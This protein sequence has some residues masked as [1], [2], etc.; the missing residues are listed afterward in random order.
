MIGTFGGARPDFATEAMGINEGDTYLTLRPMSTW[1]RLHTREALIA[2]LDRV[3]STVPDTAYDFTQPMAMRIDETVSGVKAD[4][5]IK[6]FGDVFNT[7]DRLGQQIWFNCSIRKPSRT[8]SEDSAS[9]HLLHD[10]YDPQIPEICGFGT[11]FQISGERAAAINGPHL[12]QLSHYCYMFKNSS[13]VLASPDVRLI[14]IVSQH[15]Q[16]VRRL[17]RC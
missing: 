10:C 7:L 8:D 11:H 2:A 5:I 12:S 6:V 17:R 9:R 14:T 3:L 4:L 16:N 13:G 15:Q 1:K